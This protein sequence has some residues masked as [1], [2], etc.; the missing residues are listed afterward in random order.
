ME[1]LTKEEKNGI[2]KK[3]KSGLV[4]EI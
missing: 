4:G 3:R 1:L 2:V